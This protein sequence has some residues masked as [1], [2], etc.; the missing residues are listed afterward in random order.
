M[1]LSCV[2]L[3]PM[4]V[5]RGLTRV[6]HES[7]DVRAAST[8][9]ARA[10]KAGDSEA[11]QQARAELAAA[12]PAPPAHRRGRGRCPPGRAAARGVAHADRRAVRWGSPPGDVLERD[13]S[14]GP[15]ILLGSRSRRR[16]P[17]DTPF[18]HGDRCRMADV[19]IEWIE[20]SP[21]SWSR[22]CSCRVEHSAG[23]SDEITPNSQAAMPAKSNHE[24]LP[25]ICPGASVPEVVVVERDTVDGG[26]TSKCSLCDTT[27]RYWWR[28]D[29]IETDEYGDAVAVTRFANVWLSYELATP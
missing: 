21:G 25:T 24:H 7:V 10:T 11:E 26:W 29:Y 23:S 27:Q 6:Q 22:T 18:M 20:H 19:A 9:I 16:P 13:M 3:L 2:T 8:K 28:P 4:S 12:K 1:P 17:P 14:M 15:K 5:L